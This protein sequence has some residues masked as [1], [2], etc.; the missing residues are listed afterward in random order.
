MSDNNITVG[1]KLAANARASIQKELDRMKNLSLEVTN[2]K[3]D[4]M[5]T[6]SI[7]K[8][9]QDSLTTAIKNV[10]RDKMHSLLYLF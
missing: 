5:N 7:T 2:L 6:S 1:V 10:G 8:A 9:I 3:T 4:K